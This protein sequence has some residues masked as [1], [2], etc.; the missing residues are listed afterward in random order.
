MTFEMPKFAENRNSMW[1]EPSQKWKYVSSDNHGQNILDKFKKLSKIG[2]S[3]EYFTDHF[4]KDSGK[5][6]K[7][8]FLG[9]R[10]GTCHQFQ[11]FQRF[12]WKFSIF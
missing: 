4:S 5:T 7:T 2:F 8:Y 11:V 9:G 6:V 1:S 10:L 12:Y 3:M